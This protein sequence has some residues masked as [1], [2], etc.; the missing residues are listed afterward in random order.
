MYLCAVWQRTLQPSSQNQSSGSGSD[1]TLCSVQSKQLE[2]EI[3]IVFV[4][5]VLVFI[6]SSVGCKNCHGDRITLPF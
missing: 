3:E 6:V 5:G 2:I 1:C 4:F